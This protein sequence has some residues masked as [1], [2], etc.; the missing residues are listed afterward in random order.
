LTILKPARLRSGDTIGIVAPASPVFPEDK[1]EQAKKHLQ[2]LGYRV[3]LGKHVRNMHGYLAGLD[4]ER[5]RDINAMFADTSV[6]AIFCLRGGYGSPRLLPLLD[7]ALIKRNP[8]IFVGFSDITALCCAIF[9]QTGLITFSGPMLVSD[10][11][12]PDDFSQQN[13]WRMLTKNRTF[14]TYKN[15]SEHHLVGIK[16]GTAT[17][18]LIGGNLTLL[19]ALCGTPYLPSLDKSILYFEDIG[20]EPYR[21]DR[22]LS[23]LENIGALEK[24]AGLAIGQM[25]DCTEDDEEKPTLSLEDVI[26]DYLVP[27]PK[28]APAL[29]NLSYGHVKHKLT[30]PV[31]AKARLI[32][33]GKKASLEIME[34]VVS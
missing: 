7:Y 5:A 11:T 3:K 12:Q 23:Q 14:G 19:A 25:T 1:L 2:H 16:N 32:A 24:L 10:M 28:S 18:R 4:H 6:N 8:K 22:M 33:R 34:T 15:H 17:G 29:A 30:L 26:A 31:G 27:L 21:V 20:E 13:L 9:A